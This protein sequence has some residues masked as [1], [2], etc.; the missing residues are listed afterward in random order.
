LEQ[1][2]IEYDLGSE[3]VLKVLGSVNGNQ[4]KVGK[5]DYSLVVIPAE[6]ENIDQPTFDLLQEYLENGGKVL[7]FNPNIT[8]LDGTESTKVA[9]L[10]AKHP[11]NW[12]VS[13]SLKNPSALEMLGREEFTMNDQT[14]NGML[15]HQ[16][17]I[18][19]DG[20]LLFFVNSH[21]TKKAAAEITVK[22]NM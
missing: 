6:M 18:L 16:R 22:E 4:L 17:R 14:Q 13:E 9:E 11:E 1:L 12:M 15:Y 10:A 2:H 3:N 21:T 7:S 5:R 8:L 19:D 20:Q